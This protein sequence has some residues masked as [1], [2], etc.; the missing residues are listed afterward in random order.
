VRPSGA[1]AELARSLQERPVG[2]PSRLA[3]ASPD[4]VPGVLLVTTTGQSATD[5]VVATGDR[6]GQAEQLARRVARVEADPGAA[7]A[8]AATLA[9]QP[10]VLA[11]EPAQRM[12]ALAAPDDRLYHRQWAHQLTGVERAWDAGT[13]SRD[14]VVAVLD[15]GVDARHP[16]LVRRVVDQRRFARGV[17]TVRPAGSD[18]RRCG[19][20]HGTHVAGII[21]AQGNDGLGVAGVLWDVSLLDYAVFTPDRTGACGADEADVIAAMQAAAA[22]GAD[23]VNLSLGSVSPRCSTAFQAAVDG[24]RAAGTVVVSAAGNSGGDRTARTSVTAA[25]ESTPPQDA[26]PATALPTRTSTWRHPGVTAG[27]RSPAAS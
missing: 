16:D 22:A 25:T 20:S 17:S 4:V 6:A 1:T 15:D 2:V 11:V 24:V 26:G 23:V 21:G 9:A 12:T 18:N 8:T 19:S 13:G 10:G 5:R 3:L 7:L 27:W 14:V